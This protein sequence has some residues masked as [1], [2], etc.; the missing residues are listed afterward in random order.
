MVNAIPYP[1]CTREDAGRG[2]RCRVGR[3][4]TSRI[5][6]GNEDGVGA[7][8]RTLCS[9]SRHGVLVGGPFGQVATPPRDA[10]A[11]ARNEHDRHACITTNTLVDRPFPGIYPQSNSSPVKENTTMFHSQCTGSK[12]RAAII[13]AGLSLLL[14]ACSHAPK[15]D[16]TPTPTATPEPTTA[17]PS[18]TATTPSPTPSASIASPT[19]SAMA[20]KSPEWNPTLDQAVAKEECGHTTYFSN[21]W[22]T[23]SGSNDVS[24][25]AQKTYNNGFKCEL[26]KKLDDGSVELLVPQGAKTFTTTAGQ[27]DYSRD[28]DV[29][30]TFEISDP[31]SDKVLDTASLRLN[32]AKEF[33]ID[34]SSVPR[35]KLK[36]VAEAAQGESRKSTINVIAIWADPKFS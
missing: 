19:P 14:A 21:P 23:L 12:R 28:T 26:E 5:D 35:L 10:R 27:S 22:E 36:V 31:I 8:E 7:R 2:E 15:P 18:P 13:A 11:T 16:A 33:S 29:T 9:L 1:G 20:S 32:E 30:V 6:A 17:S 3:L 24:A 4:H 25:I 34:V